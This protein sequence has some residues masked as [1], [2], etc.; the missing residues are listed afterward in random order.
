MSYNPQN[1]N[2]QATMANSSPVVIASNQ[3][4]ISVDTELLA[5]AALAD[6]TA[7]PT[8]TSI[9][10]FP[11]WYDGSTWDRALGNSTDGLLVN[12]GSNNDVTVTGI[13]ATEYTEDAA[14]PANPTGGILIGRKK[15]SLADEGVSDGDALAVNVSETGS[16]WVKLDSGAGVT[17]ISGTVDIPPSSSTFPKVED[18]ASFTG[19]TGV[20]AM[21]IRKATPANTS[22]NDGDYEM[23][24]MSAGRLWTSSTIDAALPAGTNAIG[25]LASNTGVTIGAVEIASSQTLGTVT[26]LTTLTGG[27]IA[28]DG[29]DS[30]NP[31]K[32]GAKAI[33]SL[34]TTTLV[35]SA[36]RT[37]VQSDL[38]GTIITRPQFPLGDLKSEV[39]TNTNGTSTAFSNFSA[40]ANTRNFITA[41]V[42]YNSSATAGTVDFRD[43]TA[44]SVL[45]T[46]PIPAGGG[47]V[48][49]AG[50][51]PYFRTTANTA[52]AFD[53]SGAL[54]TVTISV[55]GF[56]SKL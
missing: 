12:L 49:P 36:D 51:F 16:L 27:G 53:V 21:A 28:H 39:V 45:W 41:I 19:D 24:Q 50:A 1:P 47:S 29:A 43:G 32:V 31:I 17:I 11:H 55:S 46:M 25:K 37:D 15:G 30:G 9:G 34:A 20:P 2:G 40:V 18:A 7:N 23:L 42:V 56:Q 44:G 10:T 54:S 6:N 38:D 5:A 26:T 4:A 33:T 14:L 48:L 8:V 22:N 35:S 52:L 13:T 3:S